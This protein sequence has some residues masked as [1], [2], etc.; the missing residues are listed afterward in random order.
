M[1]ALGFSR[2]QVLA[3]SLITPSCGLGSRDVET[4]RRAQELARDLAAALRKD[5][6]GL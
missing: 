4:A 6:L 2:E 3:Q 1:A 5:G